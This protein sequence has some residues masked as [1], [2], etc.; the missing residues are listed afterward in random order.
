MKV[1]VKY[2]VW[3]RKD[4]RRSSD[5]KLLHAAGDI[6]E[7]GIIYNLVHTAESAKR[8][9]NIIHSQH[10]HQ[11]LH[12]WIVKHDMNWLQRGAV[13]S[14]FNNSDNEVPIKRKRKRST[15]RTN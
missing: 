12:V 3:A 4:I 8:E 1:K 15:R 9:A 6:I 13:V 14:E 10:K 11:R 7:S 5:D 2:C